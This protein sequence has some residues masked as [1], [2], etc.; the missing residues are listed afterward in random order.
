MFELEKMRKLA[1]SYKKPI[2]STLGSHS[3]LDICEGAKRE[4]FSTLVLC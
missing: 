4:G 3:A 1:D 2:I